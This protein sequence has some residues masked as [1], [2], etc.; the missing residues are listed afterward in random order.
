LGIFGGFF[1]CLEWLGPNHN[2]FSEIEG[3]AAILPTSRDRRLIYNK[4]RGFYV[5]FARFNGIRI[6]SQ[7]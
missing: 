7:W 4:L 2:Y 3:P 5:K 6:I 1:E